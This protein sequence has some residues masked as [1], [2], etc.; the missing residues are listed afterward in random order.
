[1]GVLGSAIAAAAACAGQA[2]DGAVALR[3][4]T[5]NLQDVGTADLVRSD[6]ARL[7]RLAEVIQRI[8]PNI[9]LLNEI[10]YDVVGGP[11][12]PAAEEPGR[13]AA[14][15]VEH[16]LAQPQAA[17]LQPIAYTAFVAPTNTG[18][19]SGLDLDRSGDVV[20]E[21]P[22][23]GTDA[24]AEPARKYGGDCWG[25]G[26]YPGQYGM[27]LLVDARLDIVEEEVRTFRL[28][29][30]DYMPGA[31]LPKDPETN[32]PWYTQEQLAVVR[33]SSKSHWDVPVALPNGAVLHLLCSHPT[34]PAFDGPEM[35]N[36]R[37]NY[38]EIRFW[39]DYLAD[40]PYVVDD[41]N[42]PGGLPYGAPFVIL[43]DLNADPDEGDSFKNPVETLLFSNRRIDASSTPISDVALERLD[44]DDTALFG[45]RVDYVLPST[46]I[47]T[48]ACGVWRLM[49]TG[50]AGERFPS[51]HFPVWADL[52]VPPPAPGRAR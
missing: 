49:P 5:F 9:I 2:R 15:F 41:N 48:T 36:K 26:A 34:P 16:Y 8:R 39:A 43:G 27:A 35:R 1:M 14:R 6:S 32:E 37:R 4:A 40:D 7:R 18:M 28:L 50:T 21:Y 20:T 23:A 17:G 44:P 10:A 13:N 25:F 29:P 24:S 19:P 3:V 38:D 46:G 42:R 11:G 45:L 52:R 47:E 22:P 31:F 30:W 33:L 12:V 51:D